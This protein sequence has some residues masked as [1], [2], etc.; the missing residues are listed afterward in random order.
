MHE[1][2]LHLVPSMKNCCAPMRVG[3]SLDGSVY[4]FFAGAKGKDPGS[5]DA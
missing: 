3:G 5:W 1:S 4:L 2:A